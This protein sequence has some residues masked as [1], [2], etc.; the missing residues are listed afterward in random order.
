MS[1]I[2]CSPTN[3]E[4]TSSP[5]LNGVMRRWTVADFDTMPMMVQVVQR[6]MSKTNINLLHLG[7][8]GGGAVN[9]RVG[10]YELSVQMSRELNAQIQAL[11]EAAQIDLESKIDA[12][13]SS[14]IFVQRSDAVDGA[15]PT[16]ELTPTDA[17]QH[18]F[19]FVF[20]QFEVH[21]LHGI[22]SDLR[23]SA[24]QL[25]SSS[26]PAPPWKF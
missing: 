4:T 6:M 17:Q 8:V 20:G 18:R 5:D 1:A 12:C 23:W 3:V 19:V 22:V 9:L 11:C 14:L 13:W 26:S 21:T 24:R 25:S 7:A 16:Y 2:Q 15:R 10:I